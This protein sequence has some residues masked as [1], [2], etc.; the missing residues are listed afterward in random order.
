MRCL[1]SSCVHSGPGK[2]ALFIPYWLCRRPIALQCHS[3]GFLA[4]GFHHRRHSFPVHANFLPESPA[5]GIYL[6]TLVLRYVR[7]SILLSASL[8]PSPLK[9]SLHAKVVKFH[10]TYIAQFSHTSILDNRMTVSAS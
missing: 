2:C 8:L 10:F 9:M 5:Q 3:T 7:F 1:V 6:L 4:G